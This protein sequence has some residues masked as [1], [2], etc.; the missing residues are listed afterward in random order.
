[1][2]SKE[3]YLIDGVSGWLAQQGLKSK[4]EP[5]G[6]GPLRPDL[7]VSDLSGPI[8]VECKVAHAYRS[9]VFPSLVGD[10]ILRARHVDPQPN[11]LLAFLLQKLNQ[12][13]ISDVKHYAEEFYPNLNWILLD[14]NGDGVAD[15]SGAR[16]ELSLEPYRRADGA[17]IGPSSGRG[18]LF[19]PSNRRL[20][21][22]LL[23]PGIDPRY[24]GGP[25][26]RPDAVVKLA[27]ACGL[28]QPK[29]SSFVNRFEEAGYI[30][31]LGGVLKVVRHEELL[32]DWYF[33]LK[34]EQGDLR[35]VR[36]MY[37]ELLEKIISR[38]KARYGQWN[39]PD[40]IV[41]SHYACHIHGI[42]RSSVKS[43]ML[44]VGSAGISA[45]KELDLVADESGSPAVWLVSRDFDAVRQGVVIADGLPVCDILQCYL[46]VRRSRAR[47]QEQADYI[48]K[49]IL[50]PHFRSIS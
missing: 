46:D 30:R 5:S 10:A 39:R 41:G 36:S 4:G 7:V 35:P 40:V 31:R 42:G 20:L 26:E 3:Q 2:N 23:L 43:A 49:N 37:G 47:G 12:K 38:V 11:L 21:K 44:Y 27:K 45:M 1:M 13:A 48:A 32:D 28:S 29:A 16:S 19:S 24:W 50:L 33:A 18:R 14:E 22:M 8:V 25:K 17:Q 9:K 34:H 15:I 6:Y